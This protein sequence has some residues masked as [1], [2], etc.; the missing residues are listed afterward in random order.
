MKKTSVVLVAGLLL[1]IPATSEGAVAKL[2]AKCAKVNSTS[3]SLICKKSGNKLTW[4]QKVVAKPTPKPTIT[5]ASMPSATPTPTPEPTGPSSPVTFD[6]LDEKWTASVARQNL[7][8]EYA[9]LKQP[10]SAAFYHIGPTV[11][12]DQL[13]EEKRLLTL[14]ERMFSN[15]YSPAKF[16]VLIYSEKD[17]AW[18]DEEKSQLT[19]DAQWS[20]SRDIANNPYG[21][22]FAG[23]TMTKNGG[24]MY[25]MC[26]DTKGRGINDKQTSI[27]EYF[28]LVQQ[29][30]SL[31]KMSCWLVEG[32]ATYF[33]VT[34]GVD[35]EDPT[36][37]STTV[38]LNQLANQYNPGGSRNLGSASKLRAQ[39][40][41]NSGAVKV[42]QDLE[43]NPGQNVDCLSYAAYSVGAIATEALI[44]VKGFKIYMDFVSTFPTTTDW[45]SDFSKSFGLTP[46]EFYL[47]LAPYLRSRLGG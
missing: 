1:G 27:H 20:I 2:G 12:E 23:A 28:H 41:S 6:N 33:G 35:G 29:K 10:N 43:I 42:M 32:S 45:K 7:A 24:S 9:K 40:Q 37:K 8:Q 47:K 14:A 15:Y 4:R 18:A 11:R 16:D 26:L 25:S 5:P 30:Y 44:G 46:N 39:I 3:G 17:G 38:F 13:L 22:N 36:G 34:L 21:C 31:N 19:N